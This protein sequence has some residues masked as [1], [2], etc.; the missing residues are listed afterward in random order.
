MATEASAA[1]SASAGAACGATVAC[2]VSRI[3]PASDSLSSSTGPWAEAAA[4]DNSAAPTARAAVTA[5]RLRIDRGK[6]LN[7]LCA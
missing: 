5:T 6:G 7:I 3:S 2:A 1:G 4:A